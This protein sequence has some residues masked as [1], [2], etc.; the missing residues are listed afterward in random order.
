[1]NEHYRFQ[2]NSA[3]KRIDR[4][5][6]NRIN[7]Y[8][9]AS[10]L[11][12]HNINLYSID[13]GDLVRAY[14][15]DEDGHLNFNEIYK[16]F[17][18]ATDFMM[19][20]RADQRY[21]E[22]VGFRDRLDPLVENKMVEIVMSEVKGLEALN[23][24]KENLKNRTDFSRLDSFRAID[25]YRMNSILRDDLRLFLKRN[26]IDANYLDVDNLFKRLDLDNDGRVTYTEF[27]NY[28]DKLGSSNISKSTKSI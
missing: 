18:T 28:I 24:E 7:A 5:N 9:L 4:L 20:R 11:R 3:F 15:A 27:V 23:S 10:F 17:V 19:R 12:D 22:Y 26:G 2:P 13:L 16:L 21:E 6:N 8:D 1:M 25:T 14:D